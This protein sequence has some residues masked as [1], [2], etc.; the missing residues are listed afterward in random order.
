MN[1]AITR[2][3]CSTI[4]RRVLRQADARGRQRAV[5]AARR[6]ISTSARVAFRSSSARRAGRRMKTSICCSRRSSGP[7][8][9]WSPERG[10]ADADGT[11]P[12]GADDWPWR[13]ATGVRTAP[14]ASRFQARSP[15]VPCGSSRATIPSLVGMADAG[16]CLHQSSSGL[17]LPMKLADFRGARHAGVRVRLCAGARRSPH[18][19]TRRR[20]LSASRASSPRCCSRSPRPTSAA[21]PKFA[22]ARAWLAAQS[23]RS[24]GTSSGSATAAPLIRT[25]V[26]RVNDCSAPV[27]GLFGRRRIQSNRYAS[28]WRDCRQSGHSRRPA[29]AL[30][31]I[32]RENPTRAARTISPAPRQAGAGHR[33]SPRRRAA[34]ARPSRR[35]G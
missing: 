7:N 13:D 20:D 12:R 17:D 31:P 9:R 15:C 30:R 22:A 2:D 4:G 19:R 8:A 29:R 14:R 26:A 6:A 24:A 34:K 18:A 21:V 3:R 32:H 5:A 10:K 25:A 1:G 33:A 35:S 23:R 28:D 11:R 27:A 16:L